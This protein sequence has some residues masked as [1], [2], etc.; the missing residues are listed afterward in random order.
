MNRIITRPKT[1]TAFLISSEPP[2]TTS[3]V[4]ANIPPAMGT[5]VLV[6]YLAVRK[7]MPSVTGAMAPLTAIKP[8]KTMKLSPNRDITPCLSI[9]PS[10]GN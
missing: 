3:R 5:R 9:L 2:T 1:P 4:S 7:E 10:L 6:R 8:E